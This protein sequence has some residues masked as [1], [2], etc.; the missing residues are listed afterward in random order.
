LFW[1]GPNTAMC[2]ESFIFLYPFL[3]FSKKVSRRMT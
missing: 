3:A 1:S 2:I